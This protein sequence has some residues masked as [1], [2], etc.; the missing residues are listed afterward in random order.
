MNF[1]FS[2]LFILIFILIN[3]GFST[4]YSNCAS[5][6]SGNH[7]LSGNVV[8]GAHCFWLSSNSVLDCKGY[9]I[10]GPSALS[11]IA[12][13]LTL[14]VDNVTIKNCILTGLGFAT[15]SDGGTNILLDNLT[16][17]GNNY[18]ITTQSTNSNFDVLN[19]VTYSNSVGV[20]F[21]NGPTE[22]NFSLINHTSYSNFGSGVYTFG[23]NDLY[24]ENLTSYSN[25]VGLTLITG[26][27]LN[28]NNSN[29]SDNTNFDFEYSIP[30]LESSCDLTL[31]NII[32]TG[33]NPIEYYNSSVN[34]SNK[35][36]SELI[37]CNADNSTI[38]NVSIISKDSSNSNVFFNYY[39]DDSS[40]L[41]MDIK[42]TMW[43]FFLR[44]S[45]NNIFSNITYN[46]NINGQV[47]LTSSNNT[48]LNLVLNNSNINAI[49]SQVDSNNNSF[50][51]INV[52]NT[53]LGNGIQLEDSNFN[54]F[55]NISITYSLGGS[56]IYLLRSSD[57]SF[58]N[59]NS[60][61]NFFNGVILN[62]QSNNNNIFSDIN[63]FN[64]SANGIIVV[65]SDNNNL[66]N[67]LS[68]YNVGGGLTF[69]NSDNNYLSTSLF[70][71]NGGEGLFIDNS[72]N[73]RIDNIFVNNSKIS[74]GVYIRDSS[75]NNI[76]GLNSSF[77]LFNGLVINSNSN[78]NNFS[79]VN[80]F[81]NNADGLL[82]GSSIGGYFTNIS[83]FN[84]NL[85]GFKSSNFTN[86]MFINISSYLNNVGSYF[87]LN[88]NNLTF[89]DS[90]FSN[91]L[92]G[93]G[94]YVNGSSY[95]NIIDTSVNF[96]GK[97][98]LVLNSDSIGI[99]VI[100]SSF[101]NNVG[102][103]F[104]FAGGS[105]ATIINSE[106]NSNL[107]GV[108]LENSSNNYIYNSNILGN[109]AGVYFRGDS[110]DS[111]LFNSSVYNNFLGDIYFD[112]DNFNYPNNNILFANTFDTPDKILSDFN[113]SINLNFFNS[114]KLG[115]GSV[116]NY[117]SDFSCDLTDS[118]GDY[119]VCLDPENLLINSM[120]NIYDFSPLSNHPG[121]NSNATSRILNYVYPT[122][123]DGTK[124]SKSNFSIKFGDGVT[125]ISPCLVKVNNLVGA[126]TFSDGYCTLFISNISGQRES[127]TFQA[128]S[129]QFVFEER[130][131]HYYPNPKFV[132]ELAGFSPLLIFGVIGFVGLILW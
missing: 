78:Y 103:G 87:K 16:I 76:V 35:V 21:G 72:N 132:S 65:S 75:Y 100:N 46:N 34:L 90:S 80:L 37:L 73:N 99:S 57:A 95:I 60:S 61:Y 9:I 91:N 2:V 22:N 122:F 109:V 53:T 102:L 15:I 120:Y 39:T 48:F 18:G 121:L 30:S 51:N 12:G 13:I 77:N 101:N 11:G 8:A 33:G 27:R 117:W 111:E 41:N 118:R 79:N 68:R 67:V 70:L 31:N 92:V 104:G 119:L 58:N 42:N 28:L 69:S 17:A 129:N 32:G 44:N 98:G 5:P 81:N 127:I 114:S 62:N 45:N 85:S 56:G 124:F 3:L 64:N 84:N 82:F 130:T 6:P 10:S 23:V 29:I 49:I 71:D 38:D 123:P 47:I 4:S 43:G 25:L 107:I 14:G 106:S 112:Y 126:V 54:S 52:F 113:F 55:E 1:R 66:S 108:L 36:Y 63:L 96:N 110:D 83:S 7:E 97:N 26:L 116:G 94:I 59:F 20:R 105:N 89:K 24:I 128:Y 74:S 19:S 93:D 86:A 115:F 131:V 50:V 40:Y 125:N 88:S